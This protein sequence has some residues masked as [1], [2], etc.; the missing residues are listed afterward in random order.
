[1]VGTCT[2]NIKEIMRLCLLQL[3]ERGKSMECSIKK[4]YK[5]VA[6]EKKT[7]LRCEIQDKKENK[8]DFCLKPL[9]LSKRAYATLMRF[10]EEDEK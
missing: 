6:G 10:I 4:Y 2:I 1:M 7:Y 5:V 9:F 3:L 8:F